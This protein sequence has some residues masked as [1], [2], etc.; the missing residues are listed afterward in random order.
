MVSLAISDVERASSV[1]AGTTEEHQVSQI[2]TPLP[3]APP[4]QPEVRDIKVEED[5]R[6]SVSH[7]APAPTFYWWVDALIIAV[8]IVAVYGLVLAASRWT[9]P[10]T[11]NTQIDLSPSALPLYAGFSTLRMALGYILSLVFSL[12]Y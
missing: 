10:L 5:V 9:A 12:V 11:P 8:I 6:A 7:A 3:P 2:Y 1:P 4:T